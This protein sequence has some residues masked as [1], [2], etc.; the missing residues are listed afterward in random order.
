MKA[1]VKEGKRYGAAKA[2]E[3]VEVEPHRAALVPWCLEPVTEPSEI[4]IGDASGEWQSG[5]DRPTD[6]AVEASKPSKKKK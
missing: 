2:G 4:V 3:I 1:R 5:K 6:P